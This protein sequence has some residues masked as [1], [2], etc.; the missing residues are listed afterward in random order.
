M[1][2][3]RIPQVIARIVEKQE[4]EAIAALID[5]NYD[6]EKLLVEAVRTGK[7]FLVDTFMEAG[8]DIEMPLRKGETLLEIASKTPNNA[9]MINHLAAKLTPTPAPFPGKA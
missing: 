2:K 3:N 5:A 8:W 4:L 9:K 1:T 7:T 6:V